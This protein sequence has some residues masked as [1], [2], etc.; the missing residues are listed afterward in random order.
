MYSI[1]IM[2]FASLEPACVLRVGQCDSPTADAVAQRFCV[3][4]ELDAERREEAALDW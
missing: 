4:E 3:S 1:S 2:G